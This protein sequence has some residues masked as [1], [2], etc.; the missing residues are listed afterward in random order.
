MARRP[1][2]TLREARA[3]ESDISVTRKLVDAGRIVGIPVEDHIVIG[4]ETF[5]SFREE[6]LL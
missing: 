4:E 2:P 6:E 5:S 1:V 3:S